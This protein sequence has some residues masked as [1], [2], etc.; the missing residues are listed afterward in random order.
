MEKVLRPDRLVDRYR[1]NLNVL[2]IDV[3][4]F[5][6]LFVNISWTTKQMKTDKIIQLKMQRWRAEALGLVQ[7]TI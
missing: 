4:I 3:D 5:A 7:G 6:N 1:Y 2:S